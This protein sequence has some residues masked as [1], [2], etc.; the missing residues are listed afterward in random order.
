MMMIKYDEGLRANY[1]CARDSRPR[2][3]IAMLGALNLRMLLKRDEED[4]TKE[5][6]NRKKHEKE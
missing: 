5:K 4:R 3:M 2:A 1:L 6:Q